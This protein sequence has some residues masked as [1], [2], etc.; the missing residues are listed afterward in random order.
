MKLL[1]QSFDTAEKNLAFEEWY[2]HRFEEDTLRLWINPKSVV[3]GKHQNAFAESNQAFCSQ[4]QIPIIRRISGGGTVY[5]DEGNVNFS[6]FRHVEKGQQIN[7]DRNLDI[8]QGAL[9]QLGYPVERT[10]R[11]DLFIGEHKISGN[12]QHVS[13]GKALHHGTILYS[14]DKTLLSAA[15]KNDCGHFEDK[16]VKSVRSPIRNLD[17]LKSIGSVGEFLGALAKA[18]NLNQIEPEFGADEIAQLALEKYSSWDWNFGYGP[19]FRFISRN[20]DFQ[21][22]VERG[23][24]IHSIE[25]HGNEHIQLTKKF[26]ST[27]FESELIESLFV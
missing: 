10:V 7:Y 25:L 20:S 26:K 6:F 21:V 15:L 22:I 16:S 8:I 23:G 27:R 12:A 2:F 19:A 17:E 13:K 4:H 18:I 14:S 3:V 5:H 24:L 11:H 1:V 9:V